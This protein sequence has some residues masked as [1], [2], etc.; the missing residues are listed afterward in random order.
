LA[1]GAI[2]GVGG[3]VWGYFYADDVI[4]AVKGGV[5]I[6]AGGGIVGGLLGPEIAVALRIAAEVRA[7]YNRD[8]G[9]LWE[10]FDAMDDSGWWE[11]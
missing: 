10:W 9:E 4:T 6:G 11:K 2:G 7:R 1:G 5:V 8:M 3:L